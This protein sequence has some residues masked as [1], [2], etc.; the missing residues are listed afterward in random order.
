MKSDEEMEKWTDEILAEIL[1]EEKELELRNQEI[2][3]NGCPCTKKTEHVYTFSRIPYL[4]CVVC[5]KQFD[6][7]GNEIK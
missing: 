7:D 5:R 2:I 1:A 3:K 6:L 4:M